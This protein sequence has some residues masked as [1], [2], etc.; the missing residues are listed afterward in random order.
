MDVLRLAFKN[1]PDEAR[2][3]LIKINIED[4]II[5]D[6]IK[7]LSNDPIQSNNK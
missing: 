6:L 3:L 4:N 2:K 5:S 1:S 7:K